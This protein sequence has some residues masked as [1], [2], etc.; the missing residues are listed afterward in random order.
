VHA[1]TEIGERE[2]V[3]ANGCGLERW[4]VKTLT[5]ADAHA[6][7][8][9][10]KPTTIDAL[11]ALRGPAASFSSP[12]RPG[13]ERTTFRIQA[14][15]VEMKREADRD[16]HLVVASPT[17]GATMIVELPST[18]C[19]RGALHRYAMATAR[20]HLENACGTASYTSFRHLSGTATITGVGFFDLLHGQ[21]GVAPNGIELH[22]V[23]GFRASGC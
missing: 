13:V 6:V 21:T 11:R 5:D 20:S 16:V 23:L 9:R 4:D 22:P 1:N 7:G 18:T 17:T 15:L 14:R 2:E 8:F 12:R 19:T 10:A 3:G